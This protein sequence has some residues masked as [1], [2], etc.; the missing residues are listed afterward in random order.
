MLPAAYC[1]SA[2]VPRL[3]RY[4]S[5][6]KNFISHKIGRQSVIHQINVFVEVCNQSY[7]MH[8]S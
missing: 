2:E 7:C 4:N 5:S 6:V 1:V 8:K 3:A